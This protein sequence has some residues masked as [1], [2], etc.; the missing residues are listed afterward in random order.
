MKNSGNVDLAIHA[1]QRYRGRRAGAE[2]LELAPPLL[3]RSVI[4]LRRGEVRQARA[5]APV[6]V[7]VANQSIE[8]LVG[9]DRRWLSS[10][11]LSTPRA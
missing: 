2:P 1:H 5:A 9:F 10:S 8:L 7:D 4:G 6:F 11:F 3:Q